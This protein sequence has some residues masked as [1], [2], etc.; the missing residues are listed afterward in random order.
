MSYQR[1]AHVYDGDAVC[2]VCGHDGAEWHHWKH[3]TYE[4]IAS[5]AA[6]EPG[7]KRE[8]TVAE[9]DAAYAHFVEAIAARQDD[10][11]DDSDDM[12]YGQTDARSR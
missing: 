5:P 8:A 9:H 2:V 4:G 12:E 10:D 7:C 1:Y 11:D 6:R 3:S